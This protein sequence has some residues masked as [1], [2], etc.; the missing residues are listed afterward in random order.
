[1]SIILGVALI[2]SMS[3]AWFAFVAG[4]AAVGCIILS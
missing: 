2:V 1:M 4:I 3:F